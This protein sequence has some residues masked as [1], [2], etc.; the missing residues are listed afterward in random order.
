MTAFALSGAAICAALLCLI[1]VVQIL[2]TESL[3][4]RARDLPA[5]QFFK[6]TLEDRIGLNTRDG[7]LTISLI[8]HTL[9]L[10]SGLFFVAATCGDTG[11]NW[12]G[13]FEAALFAWL[14][15]LLSD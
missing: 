1:T 10:L 4:L 11:L 12:P 6:E 13:L 7:V 2:Y 15:M 9:L 8:K 3:R 14:T 5:L